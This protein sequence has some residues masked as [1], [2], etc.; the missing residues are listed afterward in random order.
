[1]RTT[2]LT[3]AIA[4]ALGLSGVAF[5][6]DSTQSTPTTPAQVQQQTDAHSKSATQSA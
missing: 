1:M 3:F 6:Q 5:A 2:T 4:A